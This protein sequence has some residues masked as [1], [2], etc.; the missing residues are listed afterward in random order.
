[1]AERLPYLAILA[2]CLAL[3]TFG[4]RRRWSQRKNCDRAFASK[5]AWTSASVA[6][7]TMGS[8]F[9]ALWV[10]GSFAWNGGT[11]DANLPPGYSSG[12]ILGSLIVG[13]TFTAIN[14]AYGYIEHLNSP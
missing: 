4:V 8:I 9:P 5:L 3:F 1:M 13:G 10:I 14:T 12:F 6:T 11:I 7:A 2:V